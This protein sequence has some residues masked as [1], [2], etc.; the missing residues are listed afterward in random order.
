MPRYIAA[1]LIIAVVTISGA[2]ASGQQSAASVARIDGPVT[3]SAHTERLGTVQWSYHFDHNALKDAELV[4][5][6]LV[7]LTESGNLVRFDAETLSV[8]AHQ[9][10]PGRG[11]AVAHGDTGKLLIGTED[12]QIYELTSET[13]TLTPVTKAAGRVVWL[14]TGKAIGKHRSIVV[15]IDARADVMPWPGEPFKAYERR[16]MR[17]E[18]QV[19]NPLKVLIF[20]GGTSKYIPFKQGSFATPNAFLLDDSDRLWMG[21]DKGEWGGQYSYMELRTGNVHSFDIGSGV[22]GFLKVR[23]GRVLAYGGPP[24]SQPL[25]A[26]PG[27][28]HLVDEHSDATTDRSANCEIIPDRVTDC[29]P[30]DNG[31]T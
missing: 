17:I 26:V 2:W 12:G 7:A 9:V 16:S 18:R 21:P 20:A 31:F 1:I 10:V 29:R 25:A 8:T 27:D 28:R 14:S 3:G 19:V 15:V 11:I 23:D 6:D 4:A 5:H 22:L 30:G 13:L 24:R